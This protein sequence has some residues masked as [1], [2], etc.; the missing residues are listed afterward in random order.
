MK[1]AIRK[2]EILENDCLNN[3]KIDIFNKAVEEAKTRF[4]P[5]TKPFAGLVKR[6]VEFQEAGLLILEG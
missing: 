5:G 4:K 6:L 2:I 3:G 1:A